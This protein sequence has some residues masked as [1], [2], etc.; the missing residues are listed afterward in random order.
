MEMVIFSPSTPVFCV[1]LIPLPLG[2]SFPSLGFDH[3]FLSGSYLFLAIALKHAT[4]SQ[5][6]IT[7]GPPFFRNSP[8][9]ALRFFFFL[10]KI[11]YVPV[12][13]QAVRRICQFP[14]LPFP[15]PP[16]SCSLLYYVQ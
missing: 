10:C 9:Q 16:S 12:S 14:I 15:P 2:L 3:A 7:Q 1:S 6:K 8:A 4:D 11:P 13:G 5:P